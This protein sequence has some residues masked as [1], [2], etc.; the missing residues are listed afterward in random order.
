MNDF[1]R[2]EELA[3]HTD[4]YNRRASL[5][6]QK[7][8]KLFNLNVHIDLVNVAKPRYYNSYYNQY[9]Q[10]TEYDMMMS[11]KSL[12]DQLSAKNLTAPVI[13]PLGADWSKINEILSKLEDR[14]NK[15]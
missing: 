9:I 8:N 5:L 4:E 10:E 14:I 1:D 15:Y 7:V 3:E 13:I 11:L 2:T 12:I 6:C